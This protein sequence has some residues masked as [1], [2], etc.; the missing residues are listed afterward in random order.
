MSE[1]KNEDQNLLKM[2]DENLLFADAT[3]V[4]ESSEFVILGIPFDG[5]CSH[6]KGAKYAPRAIRQESYNFESL[7]FGYDLDLQTTQI[8]FDSGDLPELNSIAQMLKSVELS[9]HGIIDDGKF[10]ILLGGEHSLTPAAVKSYRSGQHPSF[11]DLAVIILDAHLDFRDEYLNLQNS[12][13]S[14][15]RRVS[16]LVG[17]EN[18]VPIGVR[19]YSIEE[20]VDSAELGLKFVSMFEILDS[21][22]ESA[23]NQ[24]LEFLNKDAPIYLSLDIDVIDPAY[25][26]GVG[27][28]EPYGLSPLEIK[29]CIDILAPR[30]AG[31]DVVEVSPPFDNGNTSSLASMMVRTVIG[32]IKSQK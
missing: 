6:R 24:A 28:P 32:A 12:H 18:T 13:C 25:A 1:E 7:I 5:T 14:T 22:I 17:V 20:K 10:P 30:L 29:K 8:L 23:L 9:T 21:D 31:F 2:K 15:A 16:E 27:T 11:A 19:S 26:P 3:S 4:Y